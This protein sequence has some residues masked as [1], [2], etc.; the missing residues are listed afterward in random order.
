MRQVLSCH[1]TENLLII[2]APK[3]ASSYIR[4]YFKLWKDGKHTTDVSISI[5]PEIRY[6][7]RTNDTTKL[8]EN[9][10]KKLFKE[11][12][13]KDVLILIRNPYKRWVSAFAQDYIKTWFELDKNLT[14]FL[15]EI[16]LKHETIQP[17]LLKE[18]RKFNINYDKYPFV[19]WNGDPELKIESLKY[20]HYIKLFT[21]SILINYVQMLQ[22]NQ[23]RFYDN[24]N[25]CY[26]PLVEN[27][28]RSKKANFRILDI[29]E[30][31]LKSI[32]DL[33]QLDNSIPKM[34]L[35][36]RN[37]GTYFT[38]IIKDLMVT[39]KFI[40]AENFINKML[41]PEMES[42]SFLKNRK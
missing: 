32:L 3:I 15:L 31:D 12:L 14:Q 5:D 33:Y 17:H 24:H 11:E 8:V 29:D 10:F 9:D 22:S 39:P 25:S 26:H 2:T 35:L 38:E 21:T 19:E 40:N 13:D 41:R 7:I 34:N 30:M 36:K 42:Y 28:I 20:V 37:E 4:D 1:S 16:V 27:L 23:I 18:F 6:H